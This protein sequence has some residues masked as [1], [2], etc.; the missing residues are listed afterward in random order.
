MKLLSYR[1]RDIFGIGIVIGSRVLDINETVK[2]NFGGAFMDI[3]MD[4]VSD[5]ISFLCLGEKGL[6]EARKAIEW[7]TEQ[8]ALDQDVKGLVDLDKID[9]E[10]PIPR[11]RKGIVCLGLNYSDHV[12]EGSK[13][14][15]EEQSIPEHPIFFT[16]APTA[17]IGPYNNIVYPRV[18]EKLDYEVELAVVIGKEGKYIAEED[19]Y[20]HIAGY[21]VFNDVSARDLQTRHGQ[22]FKGKSIDTFAPMGPYL[23]TPD[24]VVDPMNL[25]LSLSVN[26]VI[27]QDSNTSHL[28]FNIPKIISILSDGITL[29]VGDI[30]ATGTPA[31]V[32]SAHK[33]G[34]MNV[35]DLVEAKIK[36]LGSQKNR[37]VSED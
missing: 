8:I 9:V 37:V 16:K 33:L 15:D 4:E 31:G 12:A 36:G 21:S 27:R 20:T 7:V 2:N 18:T 35:G 3:T 23:V 29:E 6:S 26:G 19:A 34:L 32:G 5:M 28:I 1:K 22:W 25:D 13:T 14:L 10:A 30:I 11:P 24:E 17:V